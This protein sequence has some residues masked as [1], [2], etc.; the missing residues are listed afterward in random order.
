[1][2][3]Q[4]T[5]DLLEAYRE[6]FIDILSHRCALYIPNSSPIRESPMWIYYS[7]IYRLYFS[8]SIYRKRNSSFSIPLNEEDIDIYSYSKAEWISDFFRDV[9]YSYIKSEYPSIYYEFDSLPLQ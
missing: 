3:I 6:P 2:T 9:K 8:F 5:H 4:A 1:M 7:G